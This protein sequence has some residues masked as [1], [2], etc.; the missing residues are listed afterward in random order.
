MTSGGSRSARSC[1]VFG[2]AVA[3]DGLRDHSPHLHSRHRGL[4]MCLTSCAR[5]ASARRLPRLRRYKMGDGYAAFWRHA[6]KSEPIVV[7]SVILGVLGA[8]PAL[9]PL[10]APPLGPASGGIPITGSR[11]LQQSAPGIARLASAGAQ[12]KKCCAVH[13][14]AH[15]RLCDRAGLEHTQTAG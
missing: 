8:C 14:V 13:R 6:H 15:V 2:A 9:P 4:S 10:P 3:S 11:R 7:Y 5:P 12:R 1:P